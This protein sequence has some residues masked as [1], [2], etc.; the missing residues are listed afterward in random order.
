MVKDNK[1]SLQKFFLFCSLLFVMSLIYPFIRDIKDFLIFISPQEEV[2]LLKGL[3][4]LAFCLKLVVF[5]TF[6]SFYR[7]KN[8]FQVMFTSIIV[9][10]LFFI[11]FHF[12]IYPYEDYL[13]PSP[14]TIQGMVHQNPTF[15]VFI[16]A[17]GVWA[18]S[19]YYLFA[20]LWGTFVL[21][22]LFWALAN[23]TF[24]TKE[25]KLAYPLMAIFSGVG[26]FLGNILAYFLSD[27]RGNFAITVEKFGYILLG[28]FF[29]FVFCSWFIEKN[30]PTTPSTTARAIESTSLIKFSL[31][32][33]IVYLLLIF[34]ILTSF[35]FCQKLSTFVL[36]SYLK[37]H[38]T[39]S[40]DSY[41]LFMGSYSYYSGVGSLIIL[42][43][44]FWM[45]WKFGWFKAAL[46]PPLLTLGTTLLL[47]LYKV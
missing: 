40:A 9:L 25:A 33:K 2:S 16:L 14:D 6:L 43:L 13:Q 19:L 28:G 47:M 5:G 4:V 26:L 27:I 42:L 10:L 17:Y 24:T 18:Y 31:Q 32:F 1:N 23:Q 46:I 29:L 38:Y 37:E 15:R 41:A 21:S 39:T 7:K 12:L 35:G 8:L 45:I 22:F 34:A 44:T 20:D 30:Q 3:K 36:K 11:G